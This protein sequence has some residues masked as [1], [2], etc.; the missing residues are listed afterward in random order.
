MVK[1]SII[2]AGSAVFSLSFVRDLCLSENLYGSTV[3]FMDVNKKRLEA[4][5]NLARRYT[6]EMNAE[7]EFQ[8]TM[9]REESLQDADFVLNVALVG[10]HQNQDIRRKIGEK[11]GYYRGVMLG[12]YHQL[13]FFLDVA[14]DMEDVCPDAWLIQCANPVFEGCNLLTRETQIKVVGLC[15][16]HHGALE[17][18]KVLG[19]DVK[20]VTFQA[21]GFN[22]CIWMTD[23]LY[24]GEDAYPLIDKWIETNAEEYWR[25]W[26][27]LFHETQMS[28][29]AVDMY[30]MFGLFPIGDTTR[31]GGWWYHTDLANKKKWYGPI[32][33][34][35]SEIGWSQY[36]E[37]L[38]KRTDEISRVKQN[39]SISITEQFP[40]TESMEQ[41]IPLINAL[42][43]DQKGKFQV[44]IPNNG[45]IQG[46]P[47]DVVVE[48][49]GI[50]S[51]RG[52]QAVS[53]GR[54]PRRLMLHVMIPRMLRMERSLEAFLTKDKRV[55]LYMLL[56]DHRTKSFQQAEALIEDILSLPFN[57]D[58]AEHYR[59]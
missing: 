20:H 30:Q 31:K 40:P 50:V 44:N 32:G 6:T 53:V 34:F 8:K 13:Q 12:R 19:L 23:F 5:D 37:F 15:H 25:T 27:P 56:E 10:G 55:L 58:L 16:G 47:D 24:K 9:N 35:D 48:V 17:I 42:V 28:P 11:H 43:N 46:I 57:L 2:G 33:G 14:R 59:E 26:T 45:A 7:L 4:V 39:P 38:K 18:A 21:P 49:P 41:H 22:H 1:I 54:L 3:S 52:I 29:A 51:G 36:L